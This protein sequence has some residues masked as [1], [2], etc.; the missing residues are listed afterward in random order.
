MLCSHRET[1]SP[2]KSAFAAVAANNGG[3]YVSSPTHEKIPREIAAL[4]EVSALCMLSNLFPCSCWFSLA[5]KVAYVA[6]Y[7][8]RNNNKLTSRVSNAE[9]GLVR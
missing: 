2:V 3:P 6:Y 9:S 7:D 1:L 8:G 4:A 5:N